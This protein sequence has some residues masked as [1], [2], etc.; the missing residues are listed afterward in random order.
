MRLDEQTLV[1]FRRLAGQAPCDHRPPGGGESLRDSVTALVHRI[2]LPA[3]VIGRYRDVLAANRLAQLLHVG[4]TP[5]ENLLRFVFFDRRACERVI[6]WDQVAARAVSTLRADAS[7][8]ADDARLRRLVDELSQ[9]STQF[10]DLWARH[11]AGTFSTGQI[12][13]NNPLVGPVRLTFESL[14]IAGATGQSFGILF[15]APSSPDERA[16]QQLAYSSG[17][18]RSISS[19][20]ARADMSD[21]ARQSPRGESDPP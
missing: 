21:G 11:D 1:Y 12:G 16:L 8:D 17:I 6:D 2:D 14:G 5:G 15:P 18:S 13:F 10:R 3:L 20:Q 9:G 4:Y 7:V 19:S